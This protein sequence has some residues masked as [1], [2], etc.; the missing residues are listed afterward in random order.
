MLATSIMMSYS[1]NWYV[2]IPCD[3]IEY[4]MDAQNA[5]MAEY[6][7]KYPDCAPQWSGED[8][9]RHIAVRVYVL[10]DDPVGVAAAHSHCFGMSGYVAI[11]L[12][13]VAAE[14]Y[15][16]PVLNHAYKCY[17]V[18]TITDTFLVRS[19]GLRP[20]VRSPRPFDLARLATL[21]RRWNKAYAKSSWKYNFRLREVKVW[22]QNSCHEFS[23][24]GVRDQG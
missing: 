20:S 2:A 15:V 4:L 13:F 14:A 10:D 12:H 7:A 17:L 24:G 23:G 18:S 6:Q 9:H 3:K 16:S 22:Y 5:T 19:T 21:L 11:I 8:P 1:G